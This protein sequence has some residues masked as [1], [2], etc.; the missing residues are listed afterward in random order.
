MICLIQADI[1]NPALN[2]ELIIAHVLQMKR[3]E[4][5]LSLNIT[6][7]TDLVQ[8]ISDFIERRSQ[9]EPLQ[10]IFGETEF[11]GFPIKVNPN[12][13][14]PRPETELL[15][16]KI[17][18]KDKAATLILDIGTGSGCIAISLKKLIPGCQ[19]TATDISE[20]ALQIAE[21]NAK[22]NDVDVDFILSDI[23][24]KVVGKFDII[25]SN[26]PYIPKN[27]YEDLPVEIKEFEPENALLAEDNGI[28]FYKNI[29]QQS[30]EYL[31]ENGKI[32]FEIGHDQAKRVKQLALDNGFSEVDVLQDLNGFER[33][34]KI[35]RKSSC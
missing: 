27:E 33:I 4:L 21:Q 16:E 8:Q 25:I 35:G 17:F 29:L 28:F 14:I 12:V 32:Y 31:T 1:E 24:E 13:F 10:Y 7:P 23:F 5:F 30:K 11:Y 20:K 22:I 18:Q 9:H 34:V 6:L 15:V 26:P 2:V 3:S 19:I